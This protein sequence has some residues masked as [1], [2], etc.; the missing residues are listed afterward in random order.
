MRL[1][2]SVKPA[3]AKNDWF[4]VDA[5]DLPLGRLSSEIAKRLKGKHKPCFTPH[6]DCGDNII[7]INAEKVRLTGNKLND[8]VFHWHTGFVGSVKSITAGEELAGRFPERVVQRGVKRMM[9]KTKLGRHMFG[10]LHVYA[11]TEHPHTAQKPSTL[12]VAALIA[13]K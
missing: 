6:V 3:E 8:L 10:K 1:T 13:K 5:T 9:P 12:D 7:V 4:V 11:G 2:D